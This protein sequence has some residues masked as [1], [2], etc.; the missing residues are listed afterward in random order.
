[1]PSR[2]LRALIIALDLSTLSRGLNVAPEEILNELPH[3]VS[4]TGCPL[5]LM[6]KH[7]KQLDQRVLSPPRA[8]LGDMYPTEPRSQVSPASLPFLESV[9]QLLFWVVPSCRHVVL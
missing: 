1:M 4:K 9:E 2:V 7:K 6:L 8:I 5:G 3:R